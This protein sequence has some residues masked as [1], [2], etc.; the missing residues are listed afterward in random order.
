MKPRNLAENRVDRR[1]AQNQN[2]KRKVVVIVCGANCDSVP[3]VFRSE[4]QVS[5]GSRLVSPRERSL[6]PTKRPHGTILA[7]ISK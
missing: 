1:L 4:K 2:G 3:A 5:L 6:M 7:R